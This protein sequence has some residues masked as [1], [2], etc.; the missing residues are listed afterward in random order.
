MIQTAANTAAIAAGPAA[1]SIATIA[2]TAAAGAIAAVGHEELLMRRS[3][4]VSSS[5]CSTWELAF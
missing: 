1:G 5:G 3:G 2:A 4:S